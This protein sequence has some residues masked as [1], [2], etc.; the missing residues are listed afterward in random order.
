MTSHILPVK[1]MR[2]AI[3]ALSAAAVL[4]ASIG[5]AALAQEPAPAPTPQPAGATGSAPSPPEAPPPGAA[6]APAD[7]SAP[8]AAPSPSAAPTPGLPTGPAAAPAVRILD[9]PTVWV[10]KLP[11]ENPYGLAADAPAALPA[12]LGFIDATMP[13]G[14]FVSV[15][16]DATGKPLS[17]RRDRDPIPSLAAETMKSIQRWTINP[18]R[19]SGQAVDTWGAYRVELSVEIDSPKVTQAILMPITPSTPLPAPFAWPAEADW[20]D[21]RKPPPPTDGS[22]SILEVDTAPLPQKAPWSADS[23]K[24]P[25][26]VRY[27]VL[28]DKTG[29]VSRAIPIEVS[30]PVLLAYFR[31][32][33]AGWIMKPAQSKGAAIESWNEL[34]ISGQITFDDEIKQISALRRAIGP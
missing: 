6:A 17:V 16:V 28:I 9:A 2:L 15:R 24:G 13:A 32:A 31:K 34:L 19:R 30:D 11:S 22:V 25:F 5:H 21:S 18:A 1:T 23:F 7:A 26:S 12:K 3:R 29:R 14:L 20:L 27:W 10:A 33:M 8:A 4:S